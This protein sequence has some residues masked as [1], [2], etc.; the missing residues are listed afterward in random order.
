MLAKMQMCEI[1]FMLIFGYK[2]TTNCMNT[3]LLSMLIHIY[4]YIY[5][6]C[7]FIMYL[8][9]FYTAIFDRNRY[10]YTCVFTHTFN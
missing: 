8:F 3:L 7:V 2:A 1:Y 9:K 6:C 5:V 4:I 10:T